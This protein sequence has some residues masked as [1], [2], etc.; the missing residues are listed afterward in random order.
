MQMTSACRWSKGRMEESGRFKY[1]G[2]NRKE[3]RAMKMMK[4]M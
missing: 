4:T 2:E 1:R 3:A